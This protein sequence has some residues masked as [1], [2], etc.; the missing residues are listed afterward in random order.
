MNNQNP[1]VERRLYTRV[2]NRV[3]VTIFYDGSQVAQRRLVNL[4]VG[5][6]LIETEDLGLYLHSLI[7]VRFDVEELYHPR[8]LSLP[9]IVR[10]F[11]ERYLAASFEQLEKGTEEIILRY[12][13]FGSQRVSEQY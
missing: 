10:W 3:P 7:A 1:F 8:D 2:V 12:T 11:N 4:S 9:A 13:G 5:G 6:L